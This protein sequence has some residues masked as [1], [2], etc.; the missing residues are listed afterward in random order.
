MAV[1]SGLLRLEHRAERAGG[2]LGCEQ[3]REFLVADRCS[4]ASRSGSGARHH[5]AERE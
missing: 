3:R 2:P 4:G 5:R 1:A